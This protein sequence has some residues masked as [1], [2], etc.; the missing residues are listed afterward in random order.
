MNGKGCEMLYLKKI[1][2]LEKEIRI[3]AYNTQNGINVMIEG[4]DK[5]HIG[6]VSVISPDTELYTVTFPTHKEN[7]ICSHWA[8]RISEEYDMPVVVEAGVHYDGIGKKQIDKIIE[9]LDRELDRMLLWLASDNSG[10]KHDSIDTKIT[11]EVRYL[12]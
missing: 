4:G 5:G 8:S 1:V 12:E 11:N 9:V 3:Q 7:V 10:R 6:A 2:V